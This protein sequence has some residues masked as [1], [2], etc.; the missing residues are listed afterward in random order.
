MAL[1]KFG[2]NGDHISLPSSSPVLFFFSQLLSTFLSA[3]T[4]LSA[5]GIEMNIILLLNSQSTW[6]KTSN[7]PLK[8][9]VPQGT[10]K[11]EHKVKWHL[12][13]QG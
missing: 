10:W 5:G 12:R 1:L 3:G 4:L 8:E 11:K 7:M 13:N 2:L 9:G 6:R